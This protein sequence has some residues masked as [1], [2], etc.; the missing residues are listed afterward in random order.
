MAAASNSSGSWT[1][2]FPTP[3]T[4]ATILPREEALSDMYSPELLIVD[5][6][7]TDYEGGIIRGSINL[8]AHSFYMN[9][10]VLYD[11]CKRAGVKRVA[12]YCGKVNAIFACMWHGGCCIACDRFTLSA[13]GCKCHVGGCWGLCRHTASRR[14]SE[15]ERVIWAT[16]DKMAFCYLFYNRMYSLIIC[17]HLSYLPTCGRLTRSQARLMV[18]ARDVRDGLQISLPTTRITSFIL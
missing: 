1:N 4:T 5:V 9:R 6:R 3:R 10:G 13:S 17:R 14:T 16:S 7:R 18:E 12:F 11:L 2:A 15:S 8:P